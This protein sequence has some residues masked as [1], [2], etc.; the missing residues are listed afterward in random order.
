MANLKRGSI[1]NAEKRKRANTAS[2]GQFKDVLH[3]SLT[4]AAA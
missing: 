1:R 3:R 2:L 4:E